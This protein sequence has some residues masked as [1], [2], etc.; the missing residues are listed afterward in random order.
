LEDEDEVLVV[1]AETLGNFVKLVGG[2]S[3]IKCLIPPLESLCTVEEIL[4]REK[5]NIQLKKKAI[6]SLQKLCLQ[7]KE[8]E[9]V[10]KTFLPLLL[11]LVEGE[12]FTSRSSSCGLFA[13]V[14]SSCQKEDKENLIKYLNFNF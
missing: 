12:W 13:V 7:V 5:V 6:S 3:K 14:F 8:E 1:L 2:S 11:K 10:E 9:E 4:V